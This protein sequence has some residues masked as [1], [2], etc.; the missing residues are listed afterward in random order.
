ML[1]NQVVIC[2]KIHSTFWHC[3]ICPILN[4]NILFKFSSHKTRVRRFQTLSI[5]WIIQLS[6]IFPTYLDLNW[7]SLNESCSKNGSSMYIILLLAILARLRKMLWLV[8]YHAHIIFF[9]KFCRHFGDF[10]SL[11]PLQPYFSPYF[12]LMLKFL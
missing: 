5:I 10:T 4:P 12:C 2:C 1:R 8:N 11:N 3:K 6:R 7:T 9:P